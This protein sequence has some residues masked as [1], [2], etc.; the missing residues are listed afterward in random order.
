MCNPIAR[1]P[2]YPPKTSTQSAR[3]TTD[4]FPID[5]MNANGTERWLMVRS[6]E[7]M[8]LWVTMAAP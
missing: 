6:D 3:V 1:T 4:W 5:A 8:P 2:R 7:S